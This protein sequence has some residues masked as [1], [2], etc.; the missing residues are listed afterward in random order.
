MLEGVER[1]ERGKTKKK[2]YLLNIAP[3]PLTSPISTFPN[4][5]FLTFLALSSSL[6]HA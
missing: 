3:T 6:Q 2:T 5:F 4:R 1:K